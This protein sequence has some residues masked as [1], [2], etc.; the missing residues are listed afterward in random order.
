MLID[1]INCVRQFF[2]AISEFS[3]VSKILQMHCMGLAEPSSCISNIT[4]TNQGE[5]AKETI[6]NPDDCL[7]CEFSQTFCKS[8]V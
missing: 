1:K 7:L 8:T 2:G 5:R 3:L 4:F 6:V